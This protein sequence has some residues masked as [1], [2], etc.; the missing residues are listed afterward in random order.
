M[1]GRTPCY[2]L[3]DW[4]CNFSA[5]GYRLPTVY[6]RKYAARGGFSGSRFPWGNTITHSQ[7]N[8]C[9]V[10]SNGVPRYSYDVNPTIG[11]HPLYATG[12][13][14]Y[15]SPVGSFAPNGYGLYDM[16]GNLSEWCWDSSG[17][18]RSVWGGN[19]D[20]DARYPRIGGARW[21]DPYT[22]NYANGLRAV[23]H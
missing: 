6:E 14:P 10:W 8:Y 16:A 11:Y 1:E 19:W 13:K 21:G 2:N 15:T 12:S 23:C 18:F 5:N 20:D 7:A 9:S 22:A 4:S 17:S 3:S